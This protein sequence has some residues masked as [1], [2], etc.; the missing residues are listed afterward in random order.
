MTQLT[1]KSENARYPKI[2]RAFGTLEEIGAVI[3]RSRTYVST[4]MVSGRADFTHREK[5]LLVGYLGKTADDVPVYFPE[6]E[7]A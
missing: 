3:N 1:T 2:R 4:R 7:D 6:E 5:L